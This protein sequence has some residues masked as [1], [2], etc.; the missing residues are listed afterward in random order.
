MYMW[1]KLCCYEPRLGDH[2]IAININGHELN[3]S[4]FTCRAYDP[5]KIKVGEVPDGTVNKPVH[6]VGKKSFFK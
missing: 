2:E 3:G 4:P 1:R 5:A 6:F